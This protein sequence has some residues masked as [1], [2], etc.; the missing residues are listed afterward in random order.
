MVIFALISG[1]ISPL[2]FDSAFHLALG[3]LASL[4]LSIL[5]WWFGSLGELEHPVLSREE[6]ELAEEEAPHL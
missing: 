1:C 3:S 2:L 6:Q 4:A 5:L